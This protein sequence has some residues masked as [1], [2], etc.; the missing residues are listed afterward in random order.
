MADHI[1]VVLSEDSTTATYKC[2]SCM[3]SVQ[4]FKEGFGEPSCSP[5]SVPSTIDN[6]APSC[7]AVDRV[8]TKRMF[9][10]RLTV[11]ELA[12]ILASTKT[13]PVM[14]VLMY[15]F[16]LTIEVPL[17][18]PVVLQSLQY[19]ASVNLIEWSRIPELLA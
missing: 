2:T 13:D 12:T 5:P 17:D 15:K 8:I 10:D 11:P 18:S 3:V 1:W 9:L 7:T 4:F 16:N 14:E 6:Y 19:M